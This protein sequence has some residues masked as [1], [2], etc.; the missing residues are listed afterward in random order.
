MNDRIDRTL[1][2]GEEEPESSAQAATRAVTERAKELENPAKQAEINNPEEVT[3]VLNLNREKRIEKMVDGKQAIVIEQEAYERE[4]HIR[5][6]FTP[7]DIQK[8]GV[9][10]MID[11]HFKMVQA[12]CANLVGMERVSVIALLETQPQYVEAAL[13]MPSCRNLARRV[14]VAMA[15]VTDGGL[16]LSLT[17]V[18]LGMDTGDLAAFQLVLIYR[19][20]EVVVEAKKTKAR[21]A[22]GRRMST[23]SSSSATAGRKRPSRKK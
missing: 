2:E 11:A 8:R 18:S 20:F 23:E 19:L 9:L 16:P 12:E 1:A 5:M 17:D 7:N 6:A 22:S 15:Y 13:S 3:Y 10:D 14:I 21:L 4:I